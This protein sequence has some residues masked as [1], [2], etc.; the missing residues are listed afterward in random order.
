M[1]RKQQT[2]HLVLFLAALVGLSRAVTGTFA[3]PSGDAAI[4]LH[5]GLL[6]LILG[7]YWIEPYFTKPSDVVI[8]GLVVFISTSTLSSPPY[9]V[10]WNILRYFSL[11]VLVAAFF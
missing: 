1:T 9:H 11:A 5:G 4:W 8:N 3:L 7:M 10:W 2:L 6:M